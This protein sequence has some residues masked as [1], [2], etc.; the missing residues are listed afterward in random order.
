MKNLN[1]K[2][3]M[4]GDLVLLAAPDGTVI[5][6]AIH[7]FYDR[8]EAV[9]IAGYPFQVPAKDTVL[10]SDAFNAFAAPLLKARAEA[11]AK[12]KADAEAAKAAPQQ[13]AGTPETPPTP[14]SGTPPA[15]TP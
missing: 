10:A 12:A 2:D 14:Q 15:P 13:A 4:R 7:Q 1:G 3:L 6:G 5:G 8:N 9:R 11:E